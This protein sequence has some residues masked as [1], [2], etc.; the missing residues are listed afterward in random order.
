[1]RTTAKVLFAAFAIGLLA[2]PAWAQD[3]ASP[4]VD[5]AINGFESNTHQSFL[6]LA[7]DWSSH[8]VVYSKPAPGSDTE[9]KVQQS[10]R[11]WEQQIRR[12]LP[13][14]EAALV[15][16][17]QTD[18][19]TADKKKKVKNKKNKKNKDKT[20]LTGLWEM[21]MDTAATSG[22]EMFP[23][24]FTATTTASCANATQPD[25]VVYNTN[26]A[27]GTPVV[28]KATNAGVFTNTG[29]PA[30]TVTITNP[31]TS[32]TASLVLTAA[33][34]NTGN[35]FQ[36]GNGTG[37]ADATSLA[38]RITAL[39]GTVGVTAT[40]SG[41]DVT[42][43]AVNA[44]TDG[45]SITLAESLT[46]FSWSVG[47]LSGGTNAATI[48][49]FDNLYTTTCASDGTIPAAY[50]SYNTGGTEHTSPV[51]SQTGDE[52]AFVQ[53]VSGV[54]NL[55]VLQYAPGNGHLGA[56]QLT[57]SSPTYPSCTAPCMIS[58]PFS[59][60]ADDTNSSPFVEQGSLYVGDNAGK[61]H[62]FINI[63]N[64]GTPGRGSQSVADHSE[65]SC[66][67]QP[68]CGSE[69]LQDLCGRRPHRRR[70]RSCPLG[71]RYR[72]YRD[73]QPCPVP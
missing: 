27:G 28:A 12:S 46:S 8:H 10:P 49:A 16:D 73:V 31:F 54:A 25:F 60:G 40:S 55:V 35:N 66:S 30:G 70:R 17:V 36:V 38:A 22:A 45:N 37:T 50:W 9:D 56:A 11:Y 21:N 3:S 1:M 63:F 7:T 19:F 13:D 23:A 53:S 42:V 24:T 14:S 44:G 64:G 57:T 47:T 48:M 65:H 20:T 41:L 15:S 58:L 18:N 26:V 6:G 71:P 4:G 62:K 52:V 67:Q 33:A 59:G 5:A 69:Y 72:F 51:V 2:M 39:G 32:P 34:N 43:T 68:G 29:T 61:L